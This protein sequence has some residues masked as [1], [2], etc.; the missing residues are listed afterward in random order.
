M[1]SRWTRFLPRKGKKYVDRSIRYIVSSAYKNVPFYRKSFD[2]AGI[3][4]KSI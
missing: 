2:R 4:P 3:D 1:I